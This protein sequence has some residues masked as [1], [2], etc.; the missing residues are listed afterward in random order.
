MRLYPRV[1][2]ENQDLPAEYVR[3]LD[4]LDEHHSAMVLPVMLESVA[5]GLYGVHVRGLGH[6]SEQ[7]LVDE[8]VPFGTVK[9][10]EI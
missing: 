1:M 7:A 3:Y 6:H 9:I 10:T 8:K 5:E 4:T 2:S